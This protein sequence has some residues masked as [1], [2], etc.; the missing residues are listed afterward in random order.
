[1]SCRASSRRPGALVVLA[2]AA[3]VALVACDDAKPRPRTAHA[4]HG[5]RLARGKRAVKPAKRVDEFHLHVDRTPF[6]A[7]GCA[8]AP[9]AADLDCKGAGFAGAFKC[10]PTLHVDDMLGGLR[11]SIAI[12][13]CRVPGDTGG[14]ARLGC[15]A[16]VAR[17]YVLF[18]AGQ[19]VLLDGADAFKK[20]LGPPKNA[21]AAL[22]F[23][24]A[25][26][27]HAVARFDLAFDDGAP[28][29]ED[30]LPTNVL[31]RTEG[32]VVRLFER[33]PCGCAHPDDAHDLLVSRDG[34][35]KRI[36]STVVHEDPT[37]RGRCVD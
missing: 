13:E 33:E 19:F 22:G 9:D 27:P 14:L 28:V 6:L 29:D 20:H 7:A 16:P 12:A 17:K 30:E 1:M 31:P 24:L 37:T 11:A 25:F 5:A 32:W 36:A 23:A 18:E 35:V 3:A 34:D 15:R 4:A 2:V 8:G 21:D 26:D 10:E